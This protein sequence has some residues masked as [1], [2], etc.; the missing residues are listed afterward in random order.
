[1]ER[2]K[3]RGPARVPATVGFMRLLRLDAHFECDETGIASTADSNAGP[4]AYIPDWSTTSGS[5]V[6]R[7]PCGIDRDASVRPAAAQM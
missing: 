7:F 4:Y 5:D 2:I 6:S 1:V 3:L